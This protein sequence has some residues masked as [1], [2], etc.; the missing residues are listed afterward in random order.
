MFGVRAD[1]MT[2]FQTLIGDKTDSIPP[3]KGYGKK[4][5][6]KLLNEHGSLQEWWKQSEGDERVFIRS[7]MENL[8]LN[9]SLVE[10]RTDAVPPSDPSEWQIQ[11][12]K[13]ED[14]HLPQA[15]H[16]FHLFVYPRSKGLFR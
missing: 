6:A 14:K 8:R 10:L 12:I 5:A 4:T 7:Q 13:P 3:I 11:K 2:D 16:D 1:Q 9:R 15:Y